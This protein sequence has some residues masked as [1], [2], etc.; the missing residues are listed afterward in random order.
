MK[1]S[2]LTLLLMAALFQSTHAQRSQLRFGAR[3]GGNISFLSDNFMM[4]D[5]KR[6]PSFGGYVGGFV[7][8]SLSDAWSVQP[9]VQYVIESGKFAGEFYLMSDNGKPLDKVIVTTRHQVALLRVP[10]LVQWHTGSFKAG[11]V[12]VVAGPVGSYISSVINYNDADRELG[13]FP[14]S[15]E[16]DWDNFAKQFQFGIT[17]GVEYYITD[18]LSV[19]IRGMYSITSHLQEPLRASLSSL[20]LGAGYRF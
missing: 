18:N 6:T 13:S 14:I 5:Q 3:I 19:D 2:L 17:A 9:E 20:S 7:N 15:Y 11:R 16:N 12:G 1:I 10:M 4:L 8:I